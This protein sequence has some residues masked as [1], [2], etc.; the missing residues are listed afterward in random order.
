MK[1]GV[2]SVGV[3]LLL[4]LSIPMPASTRQ[5]DRSKDLQKE[6]EKLEKES[7]PVDRVKIEIKISDLLLD[8]ISE[9][10]GSGNFA[11][12]EG[13]LTAYAAAIQDAHQGLVAS[14]R[15]AQKRS[16]GFREL[17]I[18]LRKHLRRFDD[19]ARML[20][21]DRRKPVE[22]VKD[23]ASGIRDRLLKALFP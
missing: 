9:S 22:K 5:D 23:L 14:G 1:Q 21:L 13:D 19:V 6:R 2:L 11:E 8:E 16:S 17:E 4:S 15:N 18:A 12:M 10:A 3:L 20:N 7:D